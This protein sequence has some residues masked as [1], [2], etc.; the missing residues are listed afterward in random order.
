VLEIF[1]QKN[2][3]PCLLHGLLERCFSAERLDRVCLENAQ[4]QYTRER[5][6]STV[7]ELMLGVVPDIHPEVFAARQ[8]RPEPAGA[9]VS[10]LHEKLKGVE[11]NVPRALAGDASADL[12]SILDAPGF[13]PGPWLPGYP[14]QSHEA[15][16]AAKP[17]SFRQGCRNPASKD[18]KP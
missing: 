2:P 4:E 10:A 6:F 11:L 12:S 13:Q 18:G 9:T 8:K 16:P 14:G 3:L 15:R 1:R 7:C 5:L 17:P